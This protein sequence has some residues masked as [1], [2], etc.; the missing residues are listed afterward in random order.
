MEEFVSQILAIIKSDKSMKMKRE[1]LSDYHESDIAD[2]IPF[3]NE[4]E[5][6]LLFKLLSDEDLGEVIAY[7]ADIEEIIESLD[8]DTEE[9]ADILEEMDSDDAVDILEEMDQEDRE[10]VLSLMEE[11]AREDAELIL[12]YPE[13]SIGRLMTTNFIVVNKDDTITQAMKKLIKQSGENDNI[14]TIFVVDEEEKLFGAVDLKDLIRARKE[15]TLVDICMENYPSVSASSVASE[16]YQDVIEYEEDIIPVIDEQDKLIGAITAHD[17]VEVIDNEKNED[18]VK[19]AALS[20]NVDLSSSIFVSIKKRIPWLVLLLFLG[21]LVSV[22]IS[23]F[24]EVISTLTTMVFFQ[25]VVLGMAG[26]SGTQSLA[27][28]VR[29]LSEED[30]DKKLVGKLIFKELR[31]G[32]SIGFILGLI[33]FVSSFLYLIIFQMP[34][35]NGGE[36][37]YVNSLLASGIIGISIM[38]SMTLSSFIGAVIPLFLHSIKIDPAVASGPLITTINDLIAVSVYYGLSFI[39]LSQ[40]VL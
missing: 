8:L 26:N 23:G 6:E 29:I 28:T 7:A 35:S 1:E 34:V 15:K 2:V 27:V 39:L 30:V 9:V 20:G 16:V 24:G 37:T 12:S 25:S 31:V 10:E 14:S 22:L 40:I 38:V 3:L 32:L 13:D 19:I 17:L 5:K 33:A 4:E 18:Y 11:E 21:F 36:F